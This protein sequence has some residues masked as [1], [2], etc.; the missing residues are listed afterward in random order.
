MKTI[1]S[2]KST[3]KQSTQY[4]PDKCES[5]HMWNVLS[6]TQE[7]TKCENNPD[8]FRESY[9][10]IADGVEVEKQQNKY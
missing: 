5:G 7:L 10:Y 2:Q 3:H 4:R 1:F 6:S 8:A 9:T